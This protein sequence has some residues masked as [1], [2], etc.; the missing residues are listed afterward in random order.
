MIKLAAELRAVMEQAAVRLR[1]GLENTVQL[2]ARKGRLV[3]E[4]ARSPRQVWEEAF[5]AGSDSEPAILGNVTNAFD[6]D[7]WTW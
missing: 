5:A 7:E 3:I 2:R 6:L 1:A 4:S